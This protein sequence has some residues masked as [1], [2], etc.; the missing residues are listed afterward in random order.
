MSKDTLNIASQSNALLRRLGLEPTMTKRLTLT[1]TKV[2]VVEYLPNDTG[3]KHLVDGK[4]A[5]RTR[6]IRVRT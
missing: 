1:P 2:T 4:V 3:H 6:T 5:T